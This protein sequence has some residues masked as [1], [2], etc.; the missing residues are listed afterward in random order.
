MRLSEADIATI[1]ALL[2]DYQWYIDNYHEFAASAYAFHLFKTEKEVRP[3]RE[4]RDRI[5]IAGPLLL[6]VLSMELPHGFSLLKCIDGQCLAW[7]GNAQLGLHGP[8]SE[9]GARLWCWQNETFNDDIAHEQWLGELHQEYGQD[10]I[11]EDEGEEETL[12]GFRAS[13]SGVGSVSPTTLDEKMIENMFK[14]E[15]YGSW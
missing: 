6:K 11:E 13:L 2:K 10:Q 14:Q 12:E 5:A 3:Y 8:V 7:N 9:F 1:H 15:M 4:V